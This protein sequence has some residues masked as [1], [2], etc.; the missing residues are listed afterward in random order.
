MK[1]MT[2]KTMSRVMYK[3]LLI[4]FYVVAFI[5]P[6]K[7][8]LSRDGL[9]EVGCDECNRRLL[10]RLSST[11]E[12]WNECWKRECTMKEKQSEF[13]RHPEKKRELREEE[14]EEPCCIL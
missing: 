12:P 3:N 1:V 5:E 7:P 8:V 9:Y 2:F 11:N 10:G 14:S 13:D 4:A 6:V